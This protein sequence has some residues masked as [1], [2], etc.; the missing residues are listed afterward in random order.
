MRVDGLVFR[1][2]SSLRSPDSRGAT[3]VIVHGIGVS[4]RYSARLHEQLAQT[5]DVHSV[6]LPG[7]GGLPKPPLSLTVPAMARALGEALTEI[8]VQGAVLIGHSMGS[9]WVVELAVQRPALAMC[10]VAIGPVT[11]SEHR[12]MLAQTA[13]LARDTLGEPP[14]VN[15]LVF[16]DYLRCGPIWYTKQLRHMLSYPLEEKVASLPLPLLVIRGGSDPIAGMD[17][18]RRVRD[19][20][21]TGSLVIVPRHRHVVQHTA[22]RAVASAINAF[23]RTGRISR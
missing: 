1:V 2:L 8:G 16:T 12:S 11:D 7:F 9:Q 23:C 17:W 20:A 13:A 18:A 22:P 19:A 10:V 15:A 14:E 3:Y 21:A 4:H 5:G 6:D